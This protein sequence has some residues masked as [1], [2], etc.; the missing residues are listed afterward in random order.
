MEPPTDLERG[1]RGCDVKARIDGDVSFI[2]GIPYRGVRLRPFSC[3][4]RIDI[5]IV[6]HQGSDF[7]EFSETKKSSIWGIPQ[8][9]IMIVMEKC[10]SEIYIGIDWQLSSKI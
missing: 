3:L 8:I 2:W 1:K 9:N 10:L 4:T 6:A 7:L 5:Y